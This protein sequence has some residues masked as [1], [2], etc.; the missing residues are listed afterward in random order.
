MIYKQ[1][2]R[3]L[4]LYTVPVWGS[5]AKTHVHKIQIFLSKVLRIVSNA[6][7]FVRNVTLH[8]DFQLPTINV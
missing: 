6:S 2:I 3:P 7:W 5:C 4:I 1:I 8:K